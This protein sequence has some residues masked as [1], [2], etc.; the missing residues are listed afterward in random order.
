VCVLHSI[1]KIPTTLPP[2]PP[3]G[4]KSQH[5]QMGEQV[6]GR[7][8]ADGMPHNFFSS[9]QFQRKLKSL[10]FFQ[11]INFLC[12]DLFD[13][14]IDSGALLAHN[15]EPPEKYK[16]RIYHDTRSGGTEKNR[17]ELYRKVTEYCTYKEIHVQ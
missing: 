5:K 14:I 8:S 12:V 6:W 13:C 9:S 3:H 7:K 11:S 15:A 17:E 16:I 4:V 2:P 10:V 1:Y